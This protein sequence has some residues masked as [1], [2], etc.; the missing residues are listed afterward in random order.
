[1]SQ[2]NGENDETLT[3]DNKIEFIS[4]KKTSKKP[5][6]E[7][8]KSPVVS[9]QSDM[10]LDFSVQISPNEKKDLFAGVLQKFSSKSKKFSLNKSNAKTPSP[11]KDEPRVIEHHLEINLQKSKNV[12]D[13]L[14][15]VLLKVEESN[16]NLI[17]IKP[18]FN[19]EIIQSR[20]SPIVTKP[21]NHK[22]VKKPFKPP[23]TTNNTAITDYFSSF[24]YSKNSTNK[25]SKI[26]K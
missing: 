11:V 8:V 2:I 23:S 21:K 22:S 5:Y 15:C 20:K 14:D 3:D 4:P 13:D 16:S 6:F 7:N 19:K 24:E 12:L 25:F 10:Q 1:M 9:F 18:T 26:N 17:S